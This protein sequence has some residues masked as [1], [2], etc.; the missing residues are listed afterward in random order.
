MLRAIRAW[1]IIDI[2]HFE[3][4]VRGGVF[5]SGVAGGTN[6]SGSFMLYFVELLYQ[7]SGT[8]LNKRTGFSEPYLLIKL[9]KSF[10]FRSFRSGPCALPETTG[11]N[12][13]GSHRKCCEKQRAPALR[14]LRSEW[15][16]LVFTFVEGHP[17]LPFHTGT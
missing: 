6:S 17:A 16:G 8:I 14:N 7:K 5:G 4:D 12:V 1:Y 11:L 10:A 9:S 15:S 3:S 13:P 2:S